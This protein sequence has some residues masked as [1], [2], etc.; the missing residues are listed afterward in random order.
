MN[1]LRLNWELTQGADGRQHL[2]MH[3][4]PPSQ[5]PTPIQL[6]GKSGKAQGHH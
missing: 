6:E 2:N 5:R 1:R 3:W 4:N